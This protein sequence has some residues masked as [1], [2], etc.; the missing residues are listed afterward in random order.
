[1]FFCYTAG[2]SSRYTYKRMEVLFEGGQG[3]KEAAVPYMDG[4]NGWIQKNR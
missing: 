3:P 1:V 2:L 4:M